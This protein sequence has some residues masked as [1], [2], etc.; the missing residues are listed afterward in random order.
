MKSA[1]WLE[2][3]QKSKLIRTECN[4]NQVYQN[5]DYFNG[6]L[7]II[8]SFR[9]PDEC[10]PFQAKIYA[11][12]RPCLL[13]NDRNFCGNI[14]IF[15]N[16]QVALLSLKSYPFTSLLVRQCK[17]KDHRLGQQSRIILVQIIAY[18]EHFGNYQP[19]ESAQIRIC[20]VSIPLGDIKNFKYDMSKVWFD[21]IPRTKYKLI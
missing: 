2:L 6:P 16:S 13:L 5:I 1:V 19:D 10:I 12:C 14:G 9:F 20:L 15:V 11:I 17:Q 7:E 4:I 21:S 18:S 3:G 8:A